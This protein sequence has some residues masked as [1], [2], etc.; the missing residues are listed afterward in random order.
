MKIAW[1]L[2]NGEARAAGVRIDRGFRVQID[3]GFTL[4][5]KMNPAVLN[6]NRR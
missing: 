2:V 3:T 6:G 4:C 1:K 5:D